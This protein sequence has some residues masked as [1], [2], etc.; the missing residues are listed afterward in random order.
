MLRGVSS[1]VTFYHGKHNMSQLFKIFKF[2]SESKLIYKE[3]CPKKCA[4]FKFNISTLRN[5]KNLQLKV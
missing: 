2:K 5:K 1:H 4:C 3:K